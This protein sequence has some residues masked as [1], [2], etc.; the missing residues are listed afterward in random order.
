MTTRK[1]LEK[2]LSQKRIVKVRLV[3]DLNYGQNHQPR[4]R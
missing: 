2:S 4:N 3:T 1:E